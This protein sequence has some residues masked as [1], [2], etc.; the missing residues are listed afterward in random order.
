MI[1]TTL[2]FAMHILVRSYSILSPVGQLL[3]F[4]LPYRTMAKAVAGKI[5]FNTK[6]LKRGDPLPPYNGKLRVYNMRLCPFA[7]RTILALNAKNIDYEIV[8]INLA[9]KPE[10]LTSKSAFGK[11]PSIE[12]KEGVCIYESLITVEYLDEVYPQRPLLP[13][14]PVRK[15]MDKIIVEASGPIVTFFLKSIKAPE[16]ITEE[17][18]S[19]FHK[20]LEFIQDQ[21]KE[22][23]TPYLAGD[24]PG[25]VDY[26]NWPWFERLLVFKEEDPRVKIDPEK[27][28]LLTAYLEKMKKDPAVVPY[29][30]P[31]KVMIAF[32]E[33]FK[34]GSTP[35]YDLLM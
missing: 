22:R 13:K 26:M 19:A 16:T 18:V 8:N 3:E 9:E 31:D 20:A 34:T 32:H 6:H 17:T 14:D 12:I 21:L 10:W 1:T 27:F 33:A 24:A 11:V 29:L 35:N 4:V 5:N 2:S 28:K 15:A 30:V 7:Q 25:Y 23:G